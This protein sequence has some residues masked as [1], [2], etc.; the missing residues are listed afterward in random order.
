MDTQKNGA[1]KITLNPSTVPST[2]LNLN[3]AVIK[4]RTYNASGEEVLETKTYNQFLL[5]EISVTVDVEREL[6]NPDKQTAFI[7]CGCE[8][9]T[10][11]TKKKTG[12][13]NTTFTTLGS[14]IVYKTASCIASEEG[15]YIGGHVYYPETARVNTNAKKGDKLIVDG[16]TS[17]SLNQIHYETTV[18]KDNGYLKLLNGCYTITNIRTNIS[19]NITVD[20]T[21]TDPDSVNRFGIHNTTKRDIVLNLTT[22]ETGEKTTYITKNGNQTIV[23]KLDNGTT[24]GDM[25]DMKNGGYSSYF[26]VSGKQNS[27]TSDG[28][29]VQY[30]YI[31]ENSNGEK[32]SV[33]EE[34][35]T[36]GDVNLDNKVDILDYIAL[37]KFILG[38][39]NLIS[40]ASNEKKLTASVNADLNNDGEVDVFDL[41]LLKRMLTTA[42]FVV[43]LP[44]SLRTKA[45]KNAH[46]ITGHGDVMLLCNA[47]VVKKITADEFDKGLVTFN[48]YNNENQYFLKVATYKGSDYYV[49]YK[50]DAQTNAW[51]YQTTSERTGLSLRYVKGLSQ[52]AREDGIEDAQF[53]FA[54]FYPYVNNYEILRGEN[55]AIKTSVRRFT[56]QEFLDGK[57][58]IAVA[59]DTGYRNLLLV[60]I[61]NS[62]GTATC[63]VYEFVG[64]TPV[65][66]TTYTA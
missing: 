1:A 29:D 59:S 20:T 7:F 53:M 60:Y 13:D 49:Y 30:G 48:D 62:S 50:W 14:D 24:N 34:I 10:D 23:T 57:A 12:T 27:A 64:I 5:G 41:G 19:A 37:N 55:F 61:K 28:Q 3:D 47:D 16:V 44:V 46:D 52:L 9:Y 25:P 31:Y 63:R 8:Y 35:I 56:G 22:P 42:G 33:S 21:G 32:V 58:T 17:G 39:G 51:E 11:N 40:A 6:A 66:I 43:D 2:K 45:E 15:N 65:L 54:S 4:V 36:K 38:K 18:G 26:S